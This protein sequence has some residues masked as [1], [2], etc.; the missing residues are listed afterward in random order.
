MA[1]GQRV[2]IRYSYKAAPTLWRF[3]NSN[4]FIRGIVGPFRCL[5]ADTEFLTPRGW[6][7]LDAYQ[8]GDQVAQWDHNTNETTFVDPTA[9]IKEPSRGFL[10]FHSGSLV[11][12]LTPEHRVPHWNWDGKFQVR[13]AIDLMRKPSRRK[14]PTTFVPAGQP[15]LDMSDDLIRFA[16]MMH[17]DGHYPKA[18]H[19]ANLCV[20]KERKKVRIREILSALGVEWKETMSPKRP[21][22]TR[23]LFI[24]PYRG[25]RFTGRW[26]DATPAQL[27]LILEESQHWDGLF[28][29][30]STRY[31]SAFKEDADFIQY[32]AHACGLRATLTTKTYPNKP[33]W[34]PTYIVI[35]KLQGSHRNVATIRA[36]MRVTK[37]DAADGLQYCFNVPTGFFV[38]RCRDTV[39]ITGNSGKS[40]ASCVE[41]VRR[42]LAQAPG[43][44]GVRR[45]RFLVVRNTN[46][47]LEDTTIRTFHQWFPPG[48]FGTWRASDNTYVIES[49]PGTRIE[50]WF[51]ALDRPDHVKNLLS[52]EVTGAYVNEA[53]EIPWSIIEALQGRVGQ[54]PSKA[55]GGCTWAGLWM[56]TNP[57]DTDS[58]W[59][60]F[61]EETEHD[62]KHVEVF[63]QPSGLS[64]QAEN[65]QFLNGGRLYYERLAIGKSPQ[66]VSVYIH[67]EYGFVSGDRP[68]YPEYS[69]ELH[70]KEVEPVA[71]VPIHRGFDWGLSPACIFSQVLPDGR[72]LVFD[73][74]IAEDMGV[75]RFADDVKQ[76][77]NACFTSSKYPP[78]FID[79]GDPAGYQ[80]AQT[81]EKT[82]FQIM[83]AKGIP[84]E[85]G[86]QTMAIRLESVRKPLNSLIAGKPQFILHPRCTMLR[87]GFLG[88]YRFRRLKTAEDRYTDVPDKNEFSHP[89]DGLQ[90]TATRIFGPGLLSPEPT[91]G[92]LARRDEI[93]DEDEHPRGKSDTTGY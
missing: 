84:V 72:W 45:T 7:R 34:K 61:F 42:G 74:M 71:R 39:F 86:I 27:K 49:F 85:A 3:A 57:P 8:P 31:F 9:Y 90:Y 17:A 13:S 36:E 73:E 63:R 32:A 11:M 82:V 2:E 68:V 53:R 37:I 55:E 64:E 60:K 77:S 21:T 52:L 89:H 22:E 81:D 29:P 20:R 88:G 78:K 26:W 59:Y 51:R 76:H 50:V 87:K 92:Q 80:R 35:A 10:R 6:K 44:D 75:Q 24:P 18:G 54:Y 15:G 65:I 30:E 62:P 14:I 56:D 23:F 1:G 25:K 19:K 48:H 28:S 46:R 66:W 5:P 4:A 91:K 16:V 83:H 67:G 58:K 40:S 69:D 70:C 38:A 93:E 41:I 47:E 79:T 43:R 12:E 33:N